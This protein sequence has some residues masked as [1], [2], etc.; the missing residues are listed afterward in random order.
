MNPPRVHTPTGCAA[1]SKPLARTLEPTG[2]PQL[3]HPSRFAKHL[4]PLVQ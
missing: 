4:G 3:P 2:T 1:A